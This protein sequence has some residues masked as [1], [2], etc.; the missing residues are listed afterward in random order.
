MHPS[1]SHEDHLLFST[2][3]ELQRVLRWWWLVLLGA[4]LGAL[5]G[6]FVH[7]LK[8]PVYEAQAVF[9]AAI[10]YTQT[11]LMTQFEQDQ[12]LNAVGHLIASGE[13]LER[14]VAKSQAAGLSL[15][16]A[17]L[18]RMGNVERQ[19]DAFI[20]RLRTTDAQQAAYLANLWAGEANAILNDA[21][22]HA[23][24]AAHLARYLQSLESCLQRSLI[25]PPAPTLCYQRSPTELQN[26]ITETAQQLQAERQA[27]RNL[28]PGLLIQWVEEA[29]PPTQP[30][31]FGRND[32]MLAGTL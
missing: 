21:Q 32:L 1:S 17:D 24:Q 16:V 23:L 15:T 13:V 22:A 11:G 12:A 27:S 9:S 20:L 31:Q 5:C 25:V 18:R 4:F 28:F 26:L 2:Q 30:T 3:H 29:T 8:P 10:D 7:A 6:W 19:V 14:V